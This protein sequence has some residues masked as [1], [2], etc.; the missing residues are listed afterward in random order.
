LQTIIIA[1]FKPAPFFAIETIVEIVDA[2][3]IEDVEYSS[4]G[5]TAYIG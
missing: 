3:L 4:M 2:E 1:L 5:R